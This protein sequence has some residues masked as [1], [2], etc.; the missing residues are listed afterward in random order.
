MAVNKFVVMAIEYSSAHHSVGQMVPIAAMDTRE[1]AVAVLG[2]RA[3]QSMDAG[4]ALLYQIAELPL[5]VP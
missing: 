1:Q 2:E 4:S 3:L 5:E